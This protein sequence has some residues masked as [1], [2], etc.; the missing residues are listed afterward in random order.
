[1]TDDDACLYTIALSSL[2]RVHYNTPNNSS[3]D[4]VINNVVSLYAELLNTLDKVITPLIKANFKTNLVSESPINPIF[5]TV[6]KNVIQQ[7][8]INNSPVKIDTNINTNT[9]TIPCE[10]ECDSAQGTALLSIFKKLDVIKQ[11]QL[12]AYA[13]E[14]DNM[15]KDL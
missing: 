15:Q 14:L 12:I 11:A 13:A 6:D 2:Y 1:M 5:I 8:S 4:D 7:V 3:N 10:S 9:N